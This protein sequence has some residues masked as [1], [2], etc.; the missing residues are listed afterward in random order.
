MYVFIFVRI[1]W[2][3]IIKAIFVFFFFFLEVVDVNI[4]CAFDSDA[5]II[6]NLCKILTD[7]FLHIN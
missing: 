1:K 3:R 7:K 2:K 4:L 5:R 6:S